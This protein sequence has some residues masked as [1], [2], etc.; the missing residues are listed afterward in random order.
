MVFFIY[1]LGN[2]LITFTTINGTSRLRRKEMSI[3]CGRCGTKLDKLTNVCPKCN[4]LLYV[5]VVEISQQ[6]NYAL[7][8][9]GY[10]LSF[11][12]PILG[13]ILGFYM[14]FTKDAKHGINVTLLSIFWILVW[15][16]ALGIYPVH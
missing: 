14:L 12:L 8:G 11:F 3:T 9:A 1:S 7:R 2:K 16:T 6:E 5:P 15:A 4:A 13:F 10:L